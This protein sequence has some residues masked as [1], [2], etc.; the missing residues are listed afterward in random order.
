M[1]ECPYRDECLFFTDRLA[2]MPA[3]AQEYKDMYCLT[4]R[5]SACARLIV[6]ETNGNAA[7]PQDLYPHQYFRASDLV[8]HG[9]EDKIPLSASDN[10]LMLK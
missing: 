5:H 7:V 3:A 10:P 1:S 9:T 8:I 4:D 2:K 6:A